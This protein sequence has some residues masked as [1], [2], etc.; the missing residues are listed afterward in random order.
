MANEPVKFKKGVSTS[1]PANKKA[2]TFLLETDTGTLYVDD[3]S[4]SRIQI[5]DNTKAPK[6]HN[7]DGVYAPKSHTHSN[8]YDSNTSRAANTVLAAPT[9]SNGSASFRKLTLNDLP[10]T[11]ATTTVAGLMSATDKAKLDS[12][13]SGANKTI[14]DA[15]LSTTSTNPVQNK[16]LTSASGVSTLLNQLSVGSSNPVDTDYFISQY[17][18][19]G[20]T[21][22]S[23]HRRPVSALASYMKTKIGTGTVTITQNGTEKGKFTLNQSGNVT[24]ALS[25]TNTNTTYKLTKSGSTITLTGS[26]GTSTSVTD[27]DTNTTYSAGTGLSLSGTT[28]NHK[29]SVTAGTAQG[30]AN[31][32]LSF[33]GTFKIPTVTY[34]AQGHITGK[35]TTTMTM[36]ANPNTDTKNT[37]GSTDTSSK[38]FLV[39]ATSQAASSQTYS[40]NQVY[41]MNGQLNGNSMRVAEKVIMQYNSST[42][43][44]DFVFV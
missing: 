8:Y 5:K 17:A 20:T 18:G 26:D 37:A 12:I 4:T 44:L 22:T 31:K 42:E 1:L 13:A 27:S 10:I 11:A 24:V 9:G 41:A 32:T 25:D 36:P 43:S 35:G 38:I 33:G 2:G 40:D 29:N 28:F 14:V 21:T 16:I 23:Y 7:H 39:G 34:D 19:G 3:S 6:D 30:D 15:S